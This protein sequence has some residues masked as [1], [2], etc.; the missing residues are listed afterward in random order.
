MKC[1]KFD[2]SEPNST[3]SD[4]SDYVDDEILQIS[5]QLITVKRLSIADYFEHTVRNYSD[6]EFVRHYRINRE[7]FYKLV[8][9]YEQSESYR[10]LLKHNP[11]TVT[12]ADKT[13]AV[14][15]WFC[16]HKA[17]SYRDL[18]DRFNISTSTTHVL[19]IRMI[20]FISN[21][22]SDA[23]PWPSP[24]QME[25]EVVKREKKSQLPGIIGNL[26]LS[27]MKRAYY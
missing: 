16:G 2:T 17:C 15:L 18:S 21:L 24:Q 10:K 13:L 4:S 23:I 11:R 9:K 8:E 22:S 25:E 12:T 7:L 20:T 14:F 19:I 27:L 5:S 1:L 3:D 26:I 6:E